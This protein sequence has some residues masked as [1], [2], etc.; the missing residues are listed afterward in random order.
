MASAYTA[1]RPEPVGPSTRSGVASRAVIALLTRRTASTWAAVRSEPAGRAPRRPSRGRVASESRSTSRVVSTA[2]PRRESAAAVP[3]PWRWASSGAGT[4]GSPGASPAS[5]ASSDRWRG[6]TGRPSGARAPPATSLPAS[7]S[8]TTRSCR[9]PAPATVRV[10]SSPTWPAVS[11]ARR[12]RRSAARP[13]GAG[14]SRAARGP[15]ASAR[16]RSARAG[17]RLDVP[18]GGS[19][20]IAATEASS[21]RATSSS[22]SRSPGGSIARITRAG[23]AR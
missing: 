13:S 5:S 2:R 6:P 14:R 4:P 7:V 1:V 22:F 21:G 17:S 8:R 15:P 19:E 9:G 16:S 20:A 10:H 3:S 12:R 23:G 18:G 11:S